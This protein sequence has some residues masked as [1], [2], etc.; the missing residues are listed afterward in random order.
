MKIRTLGDFRKLT[1]NLSDDFNI[2]LRV[3]RRLTDSELKNLSYPYPYD[4]FYGELEF[5]DVGYSDKDL[6]LGTEIPN[7]FIFKNN[8]EKEFEVGDEIVVLSDIVPLYT[9]VESIEFDELNNEWNYYF[10]DEKGERWCENK[11][12]IKKVN[13]EIKKNSSST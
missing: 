3:R 11:F 9:K 6:C 4:T 5:D 8:I 13:Q 12:A 2:E 10:F 1:E 7:G